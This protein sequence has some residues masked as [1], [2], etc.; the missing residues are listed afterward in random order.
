[1]LRRLAG[2]AVDAAAV[3]S[4][5]DAILLLVAFFALAAH[6]FKSQLVSAQATLRDENA[7]V[8]PLGLGHIDKRWPSRR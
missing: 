2:T 1:M 4:N 3:G 5:S 7:W 8:K 6:Q